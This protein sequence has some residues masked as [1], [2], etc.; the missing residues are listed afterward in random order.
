VADV[1]EI[2]MRSESV[3]LAVA[4]LS[5]HHWQDLSEAFDELHRVLKKGGEAWIFEVNREVTPLSEEWMKK[6]YSPL[7]RKIAR[8]ITRI[9]GGHSITVECA[10][11]ILREHG[12]KFARSE[13]GQLQPLLIKMTLTKK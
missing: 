13:V 3:D 2:G 6:K 1:S 7:V 5:F 11:E 12:S 4:T 9:V 8:L 10:K